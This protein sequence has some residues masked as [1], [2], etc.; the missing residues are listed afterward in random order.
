[1]AG[2]QVIISGRFWVITEGLNQPNEKIS[3]LEG[4][5]LARVVRFEPAGH[6]AK[7]CRAVTFLALD[8]GPYSG[9]YVP[10]PAVLP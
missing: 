9:R 4:P 2:F 8:P 1:M 6:S 3:L 7:P 5:Y 10:H